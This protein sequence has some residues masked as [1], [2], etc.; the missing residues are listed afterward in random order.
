MHISVLLQE[1]VAGLEPLPGDTV[2]D[3]TVGSGGHSEALCRKMEGRGRFVCMDADADALARSKV[4]LAPPA[5]GCGCE[6]HFVEKN[7]RYLDE[8]L[9]SLGITE[10]HRALFDLGLSSVQLEESGR[11]F[12]FQ[13]DEPLRMTFQKEVAELTA[14]AII[15][16]WSERDIEKILREYADEW[17]ARRIAS[18]IG[19]ARE[20]SRITTTGMLAGLIEREVGRRGRIHPATKT[21]QAP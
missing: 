21:F 12:S 7:F 1:V 10:I 9:G 20:K 17:Q 11:G 16:T 18:A 13:K 5:G 14:E 6:F 3:G 19:A 8:A 15:N 2:L 4:K